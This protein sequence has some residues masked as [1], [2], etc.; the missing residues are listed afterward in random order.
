MTLISGTFEFRV[1]PAEAVRHRAQ[2]LARSWSYAQASAATFMDG[3]TTARSKN[4][5]VG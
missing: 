2:P 3:G 5:D 4:P 1:I